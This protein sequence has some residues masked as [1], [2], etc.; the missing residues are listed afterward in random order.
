MIL[1]KLC[2]FQ[3]SQLNIVGKTAVEIRLGINNVN[4]F[5][6]S[7]RGLFL[8]GGEKCGSQNSPKQKVSFVQ[9]LIVQTISY[10]IITD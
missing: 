1:S 2:V 3:A 7:C 10:R 5:K 8:L 4:M 6:Q 9:L